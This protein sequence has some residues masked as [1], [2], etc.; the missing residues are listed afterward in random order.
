MTMPWKFT[1]LE[2]REIEMHSYSS[3]RSAQTILVA[4]LF[5][6][7]LAFRCFPVNAA[8]D[9]PSLEVQIHTLHEGNVYLDGEL[10]IWW[11]VGVGNSGTK[12][13]NV[14]LQ[15]RVVDF[16]G[17]LLQ[18][19]KRNVMLSPKLPPG[20]NG[21]WWRF[22][23]DPSARGFFRLYVDVVENKQVV[24]QGRTSAAWIAAPHTDPALVDDSVF[25]LYAWAGFPPDAYLRWGMIPGRPLNSCEGLELAA[26][27]GCKWIKRLFEWDYMEPTKGE[28]PD[29]E[30]WDIMVQKARQSG[31]NV[32]G[33][34]L[35]AP[36]WANQPP[37][38][39]SEQGKRYFPPKNLDDWANFVKYVVARYK[40]K[41]R[42]WEVWNEVNTNQFMGS[43]KDFVDVLRVTHEAAKEVDP[44]CRI[45]WNTGGFDNNFI[46]AVYRLGG[47]PYVD[48]QGV[49]SYDG[50]LENVLRLRLLMQQHGL[51]NAEIWSTEEG[52]VGSNSFWDLH[53]E[54]HAAATI[55]QRY[56][57]NSVMKR[58]GFQRTFW[59]TAIDGRGSPFHDLWY[60]DLTPRP[61]YVAYAVTSHMLE[62]AKYVG[63]LDLAPQERATTYLFARD[64]EPVLYLFDRVQS[65]RVPAFT[66]E[67]P[68]SWNKA[69]SG[70]STSVVL[71]VYTPEVTVVDVMGAEHRIKSHNNTIR[72]ELSRNPLFLKDFMPPVWVSVD[73]VVLPFGGAQLKTD[74][75][76]TV[77]VKVVIHNSS[78]VVALRKVSLSVPKDWRTMP[79]SAEELTPAGSEK[80]ITF[81]VVIP[82]GTNEGDHPIE[83]TISG[84]NTKPVTFPTR[85]STYRFRIAPWKVRAVAESSSHGKIA[86]DTT[87]STVED[88]TWVSFPKGTDASWLELVYGAPIETDRV[89]VYLPSKPQI[90]IA[91][92]AERVEIQLWNAPE[93][94][95]RTVVTAPLGQAE[96]IV[97]PLPGLIR[98]ERVRLYFPNPEPRDRRIKASSAHFTAAVRE[99]YLPEKN[100]PTLI[101]STMLK[102]PKPSPARRA[103]DGDPNIGWHTDILPAWLTIDYGKE[104]EVKGVDAH[105]NFG[106]VE[107]CDLDSWNDATG[108]WHQI[109]RVTPTAQTAKWRLAKIHSTS[110]LRLRFTGK[111]SGKLEVGEVKVGLV[112]E[113]AQ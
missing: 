66:A 46:E 70:I 3:H 110:R 106:D 30:R 4:L 47:A 10:P 18:T 62:G 97:I 25:G 60:T 48:V 52:S 69:R 94:S 96:E 112:Q 7:A 107:H 49:H 76:T 86:A 87:N 104:V 92:L 16:W 79:A 64:R 81:E 15:V 9:D 83:A 38:W 84:A 14:D 55:M 5:I 65:N 51:G 31:M 59:L 57:E 95:W 89:I 24:K 113:T 37:D 50:M 91:K 36:R 100:A 45:L 23:F 26:K 6:S 58:W 33:M 102:E 101:A 93:K 27:A 67:S 75:P 28:H 85:L 111:A 19:Q 78:K 40:G 13:R 41:V 71:P 20:R 2:N 17:R 73:P 44:H 29:I 63:T 12:S 61:P 72:L 99:V 35:N 8:N 90:E 54:Y 80:E 56:T 82:S 77:P 43:T 103:M 22:Q 39:A 88:A 34:M 1:G 109:S 11:N 105:G 42:Y 32:V 74:A 108:S 68:G 98:L 53:K 21:G